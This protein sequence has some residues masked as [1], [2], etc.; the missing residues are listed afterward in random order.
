MTRFQW[1]FL[2]L[3][4]AQAAHSV[5]EYAGRLWEGF[6]PARFVTG[7]IADDPETGFLVVNAAIVAFGL[8]CFGWPVR[9]RWP[10][11]AVLAWI[12]V[13]VGLINGIG[14]PAWS[15]YRGGYTPGVATAPV[16]L[17][18]AAYLAW[19]LVGRP[20]SRPARGRRGDRRLLAGR[21]RSRLAGVRLPPGLR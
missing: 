2:A 17:V 3:V 16:L 20:P 13:V 7:L 1:T 5:E 15:L 8:W 18:L 19:Q 10:S 12:W 21:S 14:H 11:A 6:P 9:R 4:V